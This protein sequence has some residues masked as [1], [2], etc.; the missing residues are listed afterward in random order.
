MI[1][2]SVC[3]DWLNIRMNIYIYIPY[4]LFIYLFT[5]LPRYASKCEKCSN[6]HRK[7]SLRDIL[8]SSF[9]IHTFFKCYVF[10]YFS[11]NYVC[12][13]QHTL[14]TTGLTGSSHFYWFKS[15]GT[16][17]LAARISCKQ[18]SKQAPTLASIALFII[19]PGRSALVAVLV[20][21]SLFGTSA[22]TLK[23]DSPWEET[24]RF[25][26]PPEHVKKRFPVGGNSPV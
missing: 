18:A 6:S 24:H 5:Y 17:G 16:C 2:P 21:S 19:T 3:T 13:A 26:C 23:N 1:R 25:N 9:A 22:N 4:R 12:F 11:S 14:H 8:L 7:V 15:L 10:M 20:W